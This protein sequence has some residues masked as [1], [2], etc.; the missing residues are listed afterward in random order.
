MEDSSYVVHVF[1]PHDEDGKVAPGE[2]PPI[3]IFTSENPG[4]K[5]KCP[6]SCIWEGTM[7]LTGKDGLTVILKSNYFQSRSVI[8]KNTKTSTNWMTTGW[9]VRYEMLS[10]DAHADLNGKVL[11]L[12]N[13]KT[14]E[15]EEYEY[16]DSG[17]GPRF[18]FKKLEDG[19]RELQPDWRMIHPDVYKAWC[20]EVGEYDTY[21]WGFQRYL[22][23][24]E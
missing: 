6:E 12:T 13:A 20:R 7:T 3:R 21:L 15:V 14:K 10:Q 8:L 16:V 1:F 17:R 23:L 24:V 2:E 11:R 5:N 18:L 9:Y 4:F 22:V 19:T